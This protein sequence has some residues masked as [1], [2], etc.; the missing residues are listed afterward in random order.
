MFGVE[1]STVSKVLRQKEKYLFPDDGSR[2]PVKRT[3]G[4]FPDIERALSVWAKN[5]RKQGI[6]LSDAMIREKAR[7]FAIS[8][9]ISE[10]Q[11]KANSGSWLEK[12]KQKNNLHS[13]GRGR[14]ES[15]VT[16]IAR[17]TTSITDRL[18]AARGQVRRGTISGREAVKMEQSNSQDSH[19]T[20]SDSADSSFVDPALAGSGS[21]TS[22][23]STF[24]DVMGPA[25]PA[26]PSFFSP[27][28]AQ[29][30]PGFHAPSG[31]LG[32][33]VQQ[34]PHRPRSQTFPTMMLDP[35]LLSPTPSSS[36]LTPKMGNHALV[37]P[38][39]LAS[40]INEISNPLA[41][42]HATPNGIPGTPLDGTPTQDEARKAMK[43]VMSYLK[44][45]PLGFVEP[46]DYKVVNKLMGKFEINGE[47]NIDEGGDTN[48]DGPGDSVEAT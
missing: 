32:L 26:S 16:G 38:P 1:R 39:G 24:G 27:D 22:M 30:S 45:Q 13:N 25:S 17:G 10:S 8:V 36:P 6:T 48:M 3:K 33:G 23:S 40:P 34:Q 44:Q 14:S 28:S 7:F 9:G 47:G 41:S 15:D 19:N 42:P 21:A 29:P 37:R 43:V 31:C 12:F 46:S 11:F 4:K 5:T 35:S 20:T 2:S 18:A